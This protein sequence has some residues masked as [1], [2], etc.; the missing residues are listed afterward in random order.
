[1]YL[2][3]TNVISELRKLRP[4]GAVVQ[5]LRNVPDEALLLSAMTIGELQAGVELTRRQNPAKASEIEEWIDAICASHDVLPM[6]AAVSREWARLMAGR[7]NNLLE[8]AIIAATAR[9]HGLTVATRNVK[10][11]EI[12]SVPIVNPFE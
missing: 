3:D 6:D 10:D 9:V 8:D 7:S 5:W 11:F 2:L 4:H 12:F 1:M